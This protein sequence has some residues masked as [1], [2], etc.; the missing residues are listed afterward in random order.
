MTSRFGAVLE[1]CWVKDIDQCLNREKA[2]CGSQGGGADLV[3]RCPILVI[4]STVIEQQWI[5]VHWVKVLTI[6]WVSLWAACRRR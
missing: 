2:T 6:A 5:V 4:D 3:I 1:V